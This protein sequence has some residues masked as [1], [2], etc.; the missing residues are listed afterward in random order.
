MATSQFGVGGHGMLLAPTSP[1]TV[2]QD[3]DGSLK[4]TAPGKGSLELTLGSNPA[5]DAVHQSVET[6]RTQL[7]FGPGGPTIVCP[8]GLDLSSVLLQVDVGLPASPWMLLAP[9][10]WLQFPSGMTLLSAD[11]PF[12]ELHLGDD[13]SLGAFISFEPREGDVDELVI[14]AA[15]YQRADGTGSNWSQFAYEVN[16]A[17][18]R[19]RIYVLPYGE[20]AVVLMKAQAPLSKT[21]ALFERAD[22]IALTFEPLDDPE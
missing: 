21:E 7:V 12:F 15:P 4:I 11:A 8:V 1:C 13:P 6:G 14:A 9:G 19:Q 16:G 20:G 2:R 10:A 5:T 3:D 18:W 17:A 22:L